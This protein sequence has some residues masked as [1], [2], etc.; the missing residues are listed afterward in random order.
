ML[1]SIIHSSGNTSHPAINIQ[2]GTAASHSSVSATLGPAI[3]PYHPVPRKNNAKA[4]IHRARR[5]LP[6]F[7]ASFA[8]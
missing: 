3:T 5:D 7:D 4:A 1:S 6:N 2:V 8:T